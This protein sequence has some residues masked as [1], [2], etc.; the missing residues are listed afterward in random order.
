MIKI[1]IPRKESIL[2]EHLVLDYNGTLAIDGRIIEGVKEI[3]NDLSK[4]IKVHVVT[5]DTFGKVKENLKDVKCQVTIISSE[6]EYIE[7]VSY[8]EA[9]NE[10]NVI[11]IGNGRND[12][13]L[14]KEAVIGIAVIQKEGASF[15]TLMN[16][17]IVCSS[18]I[19]A[20]ELIKYP[21]RI[22]A[23]MRK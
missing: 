19:D 6:I 8:I 11:A 7:K 9:L 14:L 17:D 18:I 4:Q 16:A 22:A 21:Q 1:D 23:T 2:V 10:R 12:S 3:L 15:N 20:L 5:A 13:L